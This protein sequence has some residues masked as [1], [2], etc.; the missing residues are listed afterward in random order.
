M[1]KRMRAKLGI[2]I[3]TALTMIAMAIPVFATGGNRG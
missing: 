3:I 1:S 2:A